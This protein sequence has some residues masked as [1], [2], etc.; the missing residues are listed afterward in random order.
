[1]GNRHFGFMLS[2]GLDSSLIA[3]IATKLLKKHGQP[4]PV[5]FSVGFEDSPDLKN[6]KSIAKYLNIPHHVVVITPQD[7]IDAIS[8]LFYSLKKI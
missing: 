2:G 6:A 3:S 8:G 4:A 5:A 1:M 7:C